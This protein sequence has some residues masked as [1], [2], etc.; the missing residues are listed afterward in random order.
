MKGRCEAAWLVPSCNIHYYICCPQ[1]SYDSRGRANTLSMFHK[2]PARY[3]CKGRRTLRTR[4]ISSALGRQLVTARASTRDFTGKQATLTISAEGRRRV[5]RTTETYHAVM[6]VYFILGLSR[7][8]RPGL[9]HTYN[10]SPR[11]E[12]DVRDSHLA[13]SHHSRSGGGRQRASQRPG[14]QRLA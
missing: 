4:P 6:D 1:Q 14:L 3:F 7:S 13:G 11:N 9:E 12:T 5:A 10:L 2:V 8:T